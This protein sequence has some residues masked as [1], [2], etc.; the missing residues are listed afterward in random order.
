MKPVA[1]KGQGQGKKRGGFYQADPFFDVKRDQFLFKIRFMGRV[2]Q[3]EAERFIAERILE[4]VDSCLDFVKR[5][6]ASA[7]K[8]EHSGIPEL[9]RHFCRADP[10]CHG[11]TDI[12]VTDAQLCT[13]IR[14]AKI[15]RQNRRGKSNNRCRPGLS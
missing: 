1:D 9:F 8:T 2:D 6:S 11:A 4:A 7:E 12:G 5:E 3:V 15:F 10:F 14:I 13:K